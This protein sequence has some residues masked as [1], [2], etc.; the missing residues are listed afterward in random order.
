[1]KK[2]LL[3]FAEKVFGAVQK[4]GGSE[5]DLQR[6]LEDHALLDQIAALIVAT[7]KRTKTDGDK[8]EKEAALQTPSMIDPVALP[9][10]SLT[11]DYG[12]N[13]KKMIAAGKYDWVNDNITQENFPIKG[14]EKQDVGVVL[15]HFGKRMSS[16][17]VLAEFE[18]MNLDPPNLETLLALGAAQP[19]LQREF[20]IVALNPVWA[21][22]SGGRYVAYLDGDG[23]GRGLDLFYFDGAWRGDFRFLAL[24]KRSSER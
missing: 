19:E 10:Y 5:A 14:E 17:E 4:Q 1:M 3:A 13:L 8:S 11:L 6:A 18:K 24:R 9:S 23:G 7:P 15:V 16:E 22:P 12:K 2:L 21:Y 20:P